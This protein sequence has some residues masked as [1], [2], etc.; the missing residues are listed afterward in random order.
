MKSKLTLI[1][2]LILSLATFAQKKPVA[3]TRLAG[4]DAKLEALLAEWKVAGFAVAVIEKDKVVYAKGFGYRDYEKKLPATANTL[5]AIGSCSKAFT[6]AILGQL[7]QDKKLSFSDR[8]GKHVPSL[9]FYSDDLDEDLTISDLMC[10]RTGLPRHDY[11]WYFFNT[12]SRDTLIQKIQFQEPSAGV[13]QRYQYN[14]FMFM[15]QGVIA[16]NIT[17]QSWEENIRERFFKPLA[18]NTSN[19]SMKEMEQAAEPSLGYDVKN[20]KDITKLDYFHIRGMAPAGSINSTVNEM[21]NWMK[22][23]IYGGKYNKKEIL[24][25]SYV[26]EAMS[27]QMVAS[28]GLPSKEHPDVQFNNYGYGWGLNSY[29]GHYRVSHGGN[30]DG[31]SASTTIFPS[32]SIGI[33]VLVNQDGSAVPSIVRNLLADRM[34]KLSQSDWSK[35]VK[36]DVEKNRKQQAEAAAKAKSNEKKGTKPTRLLEQFEGQYSHAG[37]GTF[38]ISVKRDSL[39]GSSG[40]HTFWLR[41]VHYDVFQPFVLDRLHKIDT[42]DKSEVRFNFRSGNDGELESVLVSGMEPNVKPLEFTAKPSVKVIK[43]EDLKK[44]IGDYELSGAIAKVYLNKAGD[45]LNLFVPGQPEYD[46][47]YLGGHKFTIKSLNGYKVEFEEASGLIAGV[48][49]IQPNGTFRAKKK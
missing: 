13:R 3:D 41:H 36:A 18:M 8:P 32:D 16:E 14:N 10:H 46:L 30:I 35:E 2:L 33:V 12:N 15:L 26:S 11:A 22:M 31:F 27:A 43:P 17:G 9:K 47:Q 4:I 25:T 23:W 21:A 37:Y 40:L 1:T 28:T 19:L 5:F 49:F 48:A 20:E 42:A 44:Y 38:K 45:A 24:P 34:L 39:F 29:K 6:S 7:R